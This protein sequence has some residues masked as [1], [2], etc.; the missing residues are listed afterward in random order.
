M[1][2][3]S[4]VS[5][6]LRMFPVLIVPTLVALAKKQGEDGTFRVRG[7]FPE[8]G[9]TTDAPGTNEFL[10]VCVHGFEVL[11]HVEEGKQTTR[12]RQRDNGHHARR[13]V[14]QCP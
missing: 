14:W 11:A 7:P 2:I 4:N 6:M 1:P 9:T 3:L 8:L 13:A 5:L 10:F 12:C